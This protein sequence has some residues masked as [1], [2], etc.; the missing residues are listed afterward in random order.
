MNS[1]GDCT[2]SCCLVPSGC[3]CAL[4]LS[5]RVRA[6]GPAVFRAR[7]ATA[8]SFIIPLAPLLF[9]S[10]PFFRCHVHPTLPRLFTPPSRE[11]AAAEPAEEDLGKQQKPQGLPEIDQGQMEKIWHQRIPQHH[12]D[13][14]ERQCS[15]DDE[16]YDPR[17]S[18][19]S[20]STSMSHIC[21]FN[22]PI[23]PG[24]GSAIF[25]G[26]GARRSVSARSGC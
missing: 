8:T 2:P 13:A 26:D 16:G 19:A 14:A 5:L 9:E 25:P 7:E 21:R 15:C 10:F 18:G 3:P 12:D 4:R 11:G 1:F 24:T 23:I 6:L 20:W 22:V 17:G